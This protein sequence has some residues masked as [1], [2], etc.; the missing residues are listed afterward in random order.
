MIYKKLFFIS[1]ALFFCFSSIF[2]QN[3]NKEIQSKS[4]EEIKKLFSNAF[5]NQ[6]ID[7]AAKYAEVIIKKGKDLK[8]ELMIIRGYRMMSIL[9]GED[10]RTLIY[11]DSIIL[12][13]KEL[14]IEDYPAIAY[15]R[16]GDFYVGKEA[17]ERA[18]DNY[19]KFN[20]YARKYNR[21]DLIFRTN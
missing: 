5:E 21:E 17:F 19:L 18:L 13:S 12:K 11:S 8:D 20:E 7:Q 14:N 6:N 9:F 2:S 15:E 10:E 4:Y 16:K 3:K 1:V